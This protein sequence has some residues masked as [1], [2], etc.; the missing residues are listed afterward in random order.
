LRAVKSM[1]GSLRRLL[2]V[3]CE[4]ADLGGPEGRMGLTPP[5]MGAIE[6]A[7][8]MVE[9]LIERELERV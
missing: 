8:D 2:L 5:V 9:S 3:G 7:A 6:Q 4:P 1:G